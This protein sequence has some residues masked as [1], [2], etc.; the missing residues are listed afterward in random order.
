MELEVRLT[1]GSPCHDT[2]GN[3]FNGLFLM[4]PFEFNEEHLGGWVCVIVFLMHCFICK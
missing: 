3:F 2:L 1:I 4:Y